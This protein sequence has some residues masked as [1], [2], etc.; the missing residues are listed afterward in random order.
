MDNDK[1]DHNK[2]SDNVEKNDNE[3]NKE[4]IIYEE[5]NHNPMDFGSLF[6]FDVEN[7]EDFSVIIILI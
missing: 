5:P 3:F 2:Y 7:I 6:R 4:M 1:L